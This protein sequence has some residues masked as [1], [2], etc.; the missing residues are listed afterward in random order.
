MAKPVRRFFESLPSR[1]SV[2]YR[3]FIRRSTP[4]RMI[5]RIS[6]SIK[7]W[8]SI[9]YLD[10]TTIFAS[11]TLA[12]H[13]NGV[14]GISQEFPLKNDRVFQRYFGHLVDSDARCSIYSRNK[15]AEQNKWAAH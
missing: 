8:F 7:A 5:S 11:R 3:L 15:E 10:E 12:E 6:E 14:K 4:G 9:F 13:E 2:K 1:S